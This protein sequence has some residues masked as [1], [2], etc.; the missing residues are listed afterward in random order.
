MI[1]NE[2]GDK[3]SAKE[4]AQE[5]LVRCLERTEFWMKENQETMDAMTEREFAMLNEQ[6]EKLFVRAARAMGVKPDEIIMHDEQPEEGAEG[7]EG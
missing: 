5:I 2:E 4:L 3:C 6:L 7:A 1:T